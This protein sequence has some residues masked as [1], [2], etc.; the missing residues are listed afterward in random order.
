L[1][2]DGEMLLELCLCYRMAQL[3]RF[4]ISDLSRLVQGE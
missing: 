1:G 2:E 4:A 3:C